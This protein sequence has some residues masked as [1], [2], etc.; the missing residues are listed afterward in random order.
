MCNTVNYLLVGFWVLKVS[1]VA[2]LIPIRVS[3]EVP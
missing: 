3:A 2:L 1:L